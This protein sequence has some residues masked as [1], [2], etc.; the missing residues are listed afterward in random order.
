M[1]IIYPIIV[2]AVRFLKPLKRWVSVS[3]TEN[4]DFCFVFG[5]T[6][7]AD[8]DVTFDFSSSLSAGCHHIGA[9]KYRR[10]E[11]PVFVCVRVC[12]CEFEWMLGARSVTL[13]IST[14][15]HLKNLIT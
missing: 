6:V 15:F 7:S 14:K 8:R 11:F 2:S 5:G 13:C 12:V 1:K 10:G 4:K 3:R 9:H